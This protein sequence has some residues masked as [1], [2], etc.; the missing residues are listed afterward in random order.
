M[1]DLHNDEEEQDIHIVIAEDDGAGIAI[2]G[3]T[4]DELADNILDQL[5]ED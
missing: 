3:F 5:S 2:R 1:S 4:T